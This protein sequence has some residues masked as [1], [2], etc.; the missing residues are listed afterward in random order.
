MMFLRM[1][2]TNPLRMLILR[3]PS[4]MLI[5]ED[6]GLEND[7]DLMNQ[8][9]MMILRMTLMNPFRIMILRNPSRMMAN[10]QRL[11]LTMFLML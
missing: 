1:T 3:N 6:D 2:F 8:L 10:P 7:L 4:R 11:S 5:L 9:R